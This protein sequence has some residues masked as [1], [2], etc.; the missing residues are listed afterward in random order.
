M[1]ACRCS[2][3][4]ERT[5]PE[6]AGL[7]V[8]VGRGVL[9]RFERTI[10]SFYKR[11]QEG[12]KP[13]FSSLQALSEV[14]QHRD[15]RSHSFHAGKTEHSQETSPPSGGGLSAK[16]VPGLRFR[17]KGHRLEKALGMGAT[18]KELRVV[19]TP[20]R[21]EIPHGAETPRP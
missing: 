8:T 9:A 1:T 18:V 20:L 11:C 4:C 5:H 16:G 10:Q 14:A 12:R 6:W 21:T 3:R 2:P 15:V 19:R 7:S 17:D 13:G